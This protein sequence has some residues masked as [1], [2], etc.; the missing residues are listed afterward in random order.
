MGGWE[1][2]SII[3]AES[4]VPFTVDLT[5]DQA[6]TKSSD[7]GASQRSNVLPCSGLATGNPNAWIN[8]SCFSFPAAGTLGNLARNGLAGPGLAEWDFSLMRNFKISKLGE[9]GNL[10]FRAEFFS[11]L[12]R[13]NFADP[14]STNFGIFDS[15]G[16][17]TASAGE[18]TTTALAE[19]EIQ[20]ALKLMF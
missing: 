11:I 15:A 20:F 17:I 2:G 10:Q 9:A 4:G 16:K 7:G 3:T 1:L 14:R 8:I 18:I 6:G 13:V 19:R 5:S 12:N